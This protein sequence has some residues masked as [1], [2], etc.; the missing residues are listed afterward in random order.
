MR[1]ATCWDAKRDIATVSAMK[2]DTPTTSPTSRDAAWKMSFSTSN[3]KIEH[4]PKKKAPA[5]K[6][7]LHEQSVKRKTQWLGCNETWPKDSIP[8]RPK[9]CA[10]HIKTHQLCSS[11]KVM[12]TWQIH[13]AHHAKRTSGSSAKFENATP[14]HATW[15]FVYRKFWQLNFHWICVT[16]ISEFMQLVISCSYLE[17]LPCHNGQSKSG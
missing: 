12:K 2:N 9:H 16:T 10:C 11:R 13:C 3:Q 8:I 5:T 1:G 7:A 6:S 14:M 15:T 17:N 4:V